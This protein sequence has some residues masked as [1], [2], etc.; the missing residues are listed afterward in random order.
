MFDRVIGPLF[1]VKRKITR[2]NYLDMLDL[3]GFPKI[4]GVN[5]IQ[6]IW[7]QYGTPL[8]Q[9]A[10]SAFFWTIGFLINGFW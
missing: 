7:Q 9:A 6:F 3:Y 8:I 10:M 2:N 4:K 5:N 1:F